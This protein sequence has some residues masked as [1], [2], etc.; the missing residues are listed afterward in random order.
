MRFA[1][2]LG[3]GGL[4]GAAHLGVLQVLVDNDLAPD[5]VVGTSAGAIAAVL[6]AAGLLPAAN[7]LFQLPSPALFR[8]IPRMGGLPLGL[9]DGRLI[10]RMFRR[11]WGEKCFHQLKVPAAVVACDLYTGNTVVYTDLMPVRPLPQG[12]I[13]GGN[14]P[15]WQAVRASISLPA[16][17]APFPIASHLLVDG[18]ITTNVPADIARLLGATQVVGVELGTRTAPKT[19][20]NAGD[21]L[22]QSLDIMSRRLTNLN[23]S[24]HADFVLSPLKDLD[25]PPNFWEVKRIKELADLGAGETARHLPQIKAVLGRKS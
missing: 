6:Y 11:I 7:L 24:L 1:L 8:H 10:E 16:I 2:A 9:L 20:N 12:I 13:M 19:F 23:L 22:L 15:V 25:S 4:K 17:F 14:V 5:L 21:V 18:G 3:G